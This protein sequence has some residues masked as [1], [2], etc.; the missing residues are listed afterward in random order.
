[1]TYNTHMIRY[2]PPTLPA[3]PFTEEAYEKLQQEFDRLTEERAQVMIRLQTAREMGDLSENGAYKYAKIELGNINHHLRELKQLLQQ[4]KVIAKP[5]NPQTVQFGC[6]V[7]LVQGKRTISYTVVSQHE[8][9]PSEGK[10]SIESPIGQAL[11][12]KKK[13]ETV[14]VHAP[15]GEIKYTISEIK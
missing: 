14:T 1:M 7:T 11:M 10:L 3:I 9:N 13:G 5:K 4:G 12:G 8:S 2:V 15:A 6:T